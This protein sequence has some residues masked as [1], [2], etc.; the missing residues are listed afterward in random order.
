M[1]NLKIKSQKVESRSKKVESEAQKVESLRTNIDFI[2][3]TNICEKKGFSIDL[4]RGRKGITCDLYKNGD[5][6][7]I[8]ENIFQTSIDAQKEVY[9]KL[10]LHLTK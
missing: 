10:Y 2:E 9:T 3:M 5:L 8:G 1:E 6:V 7:K 4:I